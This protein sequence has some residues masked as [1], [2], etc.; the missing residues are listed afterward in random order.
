MGSYIFLVKPWGQVSAMVQ[1]DDRL[2]IQKAMEPG[3]YLYEVDDF[4]SHGQ[5]WDIATTHA[6]TKQGMALMAEVETSEDK[7]AFVRMAGMRF[8]APQD[9]VELAR[10]NLTTREDK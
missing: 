8:A 2:A 10:L 1:D 5:A 6:T 4:F 9:K 7:Q 3:D